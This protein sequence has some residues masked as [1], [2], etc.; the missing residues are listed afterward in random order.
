VNITVSDITANSIV[1]FADM[2]LLAGIDDS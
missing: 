1:R 2:S